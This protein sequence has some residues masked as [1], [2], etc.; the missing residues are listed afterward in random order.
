[1]YGNPVLLRGIGTAKFSAHK[2]IMQNKQVS[3]GQG[4]PEMCSKL[5]G[6]LWLRGLVFEVR[7]E[8]KNV[9]FGSLC[10]LAFLPELL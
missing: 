9:L 2:I 5:V 7:G 4:L 8:K 10:A 6:V 3:G 1:M